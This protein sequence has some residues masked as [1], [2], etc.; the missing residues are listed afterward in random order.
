M[1]QYGSGFRIFGEPNLC[2]PTFNEPADC[3]KGSLK[4]F[5]SFQ[6]IGSKQD[7]PVDWHSDMVS[8]TREDSR[9][10]GTWLGLNGM[11]IQKTVSIYIIHIGW[12]IMYIFYRMM[13]VVHQWWRKEAKYLKSEFPF[14]GRDLNLISLKQ[15]ARPRC[16]REGMNSVVECCIIFLSCFFRI[17]IDLL[18]CISHWSHSRETL[19]QKTFLGTNW[20]LLLFLLQN[21]NFSEFWG[22]KENWSYL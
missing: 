6:N 17:Y 4:L 21:H 18:L 20:T 1:K 8:A 11:M 13:G 22:H 2:A 7:H 14:S 3:R 10:S 12:L 15:K 16:R 19:A 5:A 9:Q